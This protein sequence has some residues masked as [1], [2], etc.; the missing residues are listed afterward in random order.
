MSVELIKTGARIQDDLIV[1][2]DK[3]L[4]DHCGQSYDF[5]YPRVEEFRVKEWLP[6]AKAAVNKS[7]PNYH[8]D[9]LPVPY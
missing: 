4:C 5:H 7:H 3:V 6:K 9:S 8:A 2:P 1:H